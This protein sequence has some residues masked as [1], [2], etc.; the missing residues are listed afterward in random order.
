MGFQKSIYSSLAC[1]KC[2]V[3]FEHD[4]L[5]NS[6]NCQNCYL[7]YPRIVVDNYEIIDFISND[8][9]FTQGFSIP[10]DNDNFKKLLQHFYQSDFYSL[11]KAYENIVSDK[12]IDTTKQQ[13]SIYRNISDY[14]LG[15]GKDSIKKVEQM[16]SSSSKYLDYNGFALENGSGL[17]YFTYEF[18]KKFEFLYIADCSLCYLLLAVKFVSQSQTMFNESG[19]DKKILLIRCNSEKLPIKNNSINFIHSNQVIEHVSDQL[20]YLKEMSRITSEQSGLTYIVSPNRYSALKEPHYKLRF[21]GLYP[22]FIANFLIR[23]Q[24]R[25]SDEVQ[26]IGFIKLKEILK[27]S[28]FDNFHAVGIFSNL[29]IANPT[30]LKKLISAF[31]RNKFFNYLFNKVIIFIVPCHYVLAWKKIDEIEPVVKGS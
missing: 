10:D 18:S 11:L 26:P 6:L 4:Q 3:I 31:A 8:K 28:F 13:N 22:K 25:T 5:H 2:L 29:A 17:G 7:E 24:N 30:R 23:N 9:D 20:E 21:F 15:H 14:D 19:L 27:K 1:P 12:K 16:C